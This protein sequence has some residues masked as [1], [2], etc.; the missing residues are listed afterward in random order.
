MKIETAYDKCIVSV[1][2]GLANNYAL[3]RVS[4]NQLKPL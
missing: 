4:E 3:L 1:S 2:V